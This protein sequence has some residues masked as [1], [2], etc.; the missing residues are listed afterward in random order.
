MN[1][2]FLKPETK[3]LLSNKIIEMIRKDDKRKSE[4]KYIQL[5]STN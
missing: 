4:V 2:K 5:V 3:P 1:S